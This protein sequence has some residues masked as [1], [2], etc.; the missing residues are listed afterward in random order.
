[1]QTLRTFLHSWNK[2]WVGQASKRLHNK[3]WGGA[4]KS[5]FIT[6][7]RRFKMENNIRQTRCPWQNQ[8]T[9]PSVL[10]SHCI[11]SQC[12]WLCNWVRGSAKCL[13]GSRITLKALSLI[14]CCFSVHACCGLGIILPLS[15]TDI[16]L[17][18][19]CPNPSNTKQVEAP[20]SLR[21]KLHWGK[22]KLA[23]KLLPPPSGCSHQK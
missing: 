3:K 20:Q 18:N 2:L 15:A 21:V 23:G 16:C 14:N 4:Q 10:Q 1:M 5:H 6:R 19:L 8:P 22:N 12:K 13:I 17:N 11:W 7:R 9:T